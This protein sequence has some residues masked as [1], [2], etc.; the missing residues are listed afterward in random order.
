[1]CFDIA[2][3]YGLQ[4][5]GHTDPRILGLKSMLAEIIDFQGGFSESDQLFVRNLQTN[6]K[7]Y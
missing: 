6:E 3:H 2:L 7:L 4:Q 1:M 5:M